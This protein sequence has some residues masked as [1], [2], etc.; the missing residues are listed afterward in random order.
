MFS[1]L[2]SKSF[3]NAVRKVADAKENSKDRESLSNKVLTA[4]EVVKELSSVLNH[5]CQVNHDASTQ[6]IKHA[7]ILIHPEWNHNLVKNTVNTFLH[8]KGFKGTTSEDYRGKMYSLEGTGSIIHLAHIGR[9]LIITSEDSG[10]VPSIPYK[11][12]NS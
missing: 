6:G 3:F 5:P 2:E 1:L 11:G 9:H 12:N 7:T 4:Q 10:R 8:D